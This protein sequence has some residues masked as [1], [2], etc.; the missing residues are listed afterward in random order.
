MGV[1]LGWRCARVGCWGCR[2]LLHYTSKNTHGILWC[3]VLSWLLLHQLL[4]ITEFV[5]A[6]ITEHIKATH[7]LPF[8][9]GMSAV[10][11]QITGVLIVCWTVCSG[12]DQRQHQSST[13]LA[14]VRQIYR[15]NSLQK[16]PVTR[17][18]F[19]F[20][21]VIKSTMRYNDEMSLQLSLR[22]WPF[23]WKITYYTPSLCPGLAMHKKGIT[24]YVFMFWDAV[25]FLWLYHQFCT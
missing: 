23:W 9:R 4:L 1:G 22:Y 10:A 20:D 16:G 19:P 21:A 8:M 24:I 3:T 11:S 5:P 6:F 13:S 14:F 2:V 7:Y 17:K 18:M 25:Q 15:L 12:A